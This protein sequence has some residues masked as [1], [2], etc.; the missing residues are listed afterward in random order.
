MERVADRKPA[1]VFPVSVESCAKA[2]A[3]LRKCMEGKV[4]L[5]RHIAA[6]DQ[7]L[8]EDERRRREP[9]VEVE[10]DSRWRW[11]TG[12]MKTEEEVKAS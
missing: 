1:E 9:D 8:E 10:Q 7:G 2:T 5:A 3:A 4:A 6:M 12:M 11:W